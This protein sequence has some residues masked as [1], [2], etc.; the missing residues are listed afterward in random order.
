MATNE[1]DKR[2]QIQQRILR[3]TDL[4]DEPPEMLI[5]IGGYEDMPIV[6]L[7]KAVEPLISFLPAIQ[8]YTYAAKQRCKMPPAD[9]LTIDESASI[10]LYSMGWK[11]LNQCLYVAL[12]A[13]LRSADRNKLKPWFLYLK[14]FLTALSRLPS[15]HR[16]VF[17]G[18]K[19]D[20]HTRYL[21]DKTIVWWGFSS[22]SV[23]VDV[24]HSE[25]CLGTTGT[26]T[27]FTIECFSGKDIR[28]HT[29]CSLEDEI[30]LFAATQFKV[31]DCFNQDN[32]LHMIQLQE[33]QSPIALRHQLLLPCESNTRS[34]GKKKYAIVKRRDQTIKKSVRYV[35]KNLFL[36]F[37]YTSL[38]FIRCHDRQKN[39]SKC[40][41]GLSKA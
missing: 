7:E 20:L 10:M 28:Q 21:K 19:L 25:L 41:C 12:N 16:V 24:L 34:F 11:P 26:R 27:I 35:S 22:C 38:S 2:E 40:G 37:Y 9:G 39:R 14:L 4:V 30:L 23:S 18:V 6:T 5:P 1:E 13:V 29:Y 31:I 17:R 3:F 33:I 8:R 36:Y 32:G 15:T